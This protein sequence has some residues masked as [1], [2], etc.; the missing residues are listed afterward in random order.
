MIEIQQTIERFLKACTEPVLCEPGEESLLITADN[1]VLES[2]NGFLSLQ[3][4]DDRR[5]LVRRVT[6]IED[7][8]H[9][10]LV[11]RIERFAKRSGTLSLVDLRRTAGQNLELRSTRLEFRELF[12]RFLRRQFPAHKIAELTTEADLE[13]WD[14]EGA[15]STFRKYYSEYHDLAL[16]YGLDPA[17]K[18]TKLDISET[19]RW[20]GYKP[21]Y[22]LA[23]LLS[24]LAAY[25]DT[26]PPQLVEA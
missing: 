24:E 18:P 9:G 5:N 25:G 12:R 22:S 15:G 16:S 13:H 20:L 19:V 10:K 21:S 14:A 26:G 6:G 3:A 11:L 23:N 4:W 7:E 1:F 2:R 8:S 17:V